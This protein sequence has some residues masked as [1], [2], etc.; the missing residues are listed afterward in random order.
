MRKLFTPYNISKILKDLNFNEQ[1]I[2]EFY[3]EEFEFSSVKQKY[4][5]TTPNHF[6]IKNT[7]TSPMYQQVTDWLRDIHGIDVAPVRSLPRPH[8]SW[9][10]E[11]SYMR[12]DILNVGKQYEVKLQAYPNVDRGV[13]ESGTY[14]EALRAGIEEALEILKLNKNGKNSI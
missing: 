11:V 13:E 1:C 2:A 9:H 8:N 10:A 12:N 5:N 14:Y 4:T 3:N 7:C 6:D